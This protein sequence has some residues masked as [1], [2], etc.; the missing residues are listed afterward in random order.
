M[1]CNK[2]SE[3]MLCLGLRIRGKAGDVQMN[4][5]A[6][7]EGKEVSISGRESE[8]RKRCEKKRVRFREE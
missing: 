6:D 5:Q 3:A 8:V 1:Y 2:T 4:H 7:F